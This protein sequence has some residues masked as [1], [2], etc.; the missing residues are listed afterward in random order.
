M[1]QAKMPVQVFSWICVPSFAHCSKIR[2]VILLCDLNSFGRP[3]VLSHK[4]L[5][6]L[7][8]GC[9]AVKIGYAA[10][11]VCPSWDEVTNQNMRVLF[12]SFANS[13]W[14]GKSFLEAQ[15]CLDNFKQVR[16]YF[17]F[18]PIPSSPPPLLPILFSVIMHREIRAFF[19][20]DCS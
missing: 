11:M 12:E 1:P 7:K 14:N 3:I 15:T 6:E 2:N 4:L 18:H 10:K 17:I 8:T 9:S 13:M 5:D 16:E 19:L 20:F